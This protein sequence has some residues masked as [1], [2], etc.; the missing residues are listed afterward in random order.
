[1]STAGRAPVPTTTW[2]ASI[3]SSGGAHRD[4][5]AVVA[6]DDLLDLGA[7]EHADAVPLGGVLDVRGHVGVE[8]AHDL[9]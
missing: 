3:V 8:R 7:D 4:R 1:M 5:P 6:E 9:A 2:S